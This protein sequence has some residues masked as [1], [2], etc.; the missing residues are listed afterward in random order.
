LQS[1][2]QTLAKYLFKFG[3]VIPLFWVFGAIMV[4]HPMSPLAQHTPWPPDEA[5]VAWYNQNIRTEEDKVE[6]ITLMHEIE[7][8]WAKRCGIALGLF[9]CFSLAVGL[10]VFAILKVT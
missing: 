10:T 1:E 6:F 4:I 8:K 7:M 9:M 2:P 3:F 5:F